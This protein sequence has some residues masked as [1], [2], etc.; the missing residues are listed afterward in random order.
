M[1]AKPN[2]HVASLDQVW[3]SAKQLAESN[4]LEDYGVL[5]AQGQANDY[6]VVVTRESPEKQFTRQRCD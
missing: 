2:G 5:V 3:A 6:L 4:R 1:E